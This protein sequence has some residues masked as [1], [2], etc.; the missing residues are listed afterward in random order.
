MSRPRVGRSPGRHLPAGYPC[1]REHQAH[2]TVEGLSL[3]FLAAFEM[4]HGSPPAVSAHA[5]EAAEIS[6]RSGDLEC[7][8]WA[9]LA[10][11]IASMQQPEVEAGP[12]SACRLVRE[13]LQHFEH[14]DAGWGVSPAAVI[15]AA[16]LNN[17]GNRTDAAR[18]LI[19]SDALRAAVGAVH[20]PF[21]AATGEKV[22]A[23]TSD[24]LGADEIDRVR[25]ESISQPRDL[26]QHSLHLLTPPL[27]Q[28]GWV[29]VDQPHAAPM[30]AALIRDNQVWRVI[31]G[32]DDRHIPTVLAW[33][34]SST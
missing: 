2:L 20:V 28:P 11:A 19:R 9:N 5:R 30:K 31:H 21:I 15:V 1:W 23:D 3:V 17:A 33:T 32:D 4:D 25:Q 26:A 7:L 29:A 16:L 6:E 12:A 13:S 34:T 27:A 24:A 14:L 8:G 22:W 10:D 18:L